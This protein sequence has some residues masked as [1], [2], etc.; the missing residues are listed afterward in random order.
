[1]YNHPPLIITERNG[2]LSMSTKVENSFFNGCFHGS[3]SIC[4]NAFFHAPPLNSNR[5]AAA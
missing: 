2:T 1:M 4:K 3:P 5:I